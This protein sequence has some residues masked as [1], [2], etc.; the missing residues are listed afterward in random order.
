MLDGSGCW[1]NIAA[2]SA[3]PASLSAGSGRS[4]PSMITCSTL[5]VTENWQPVSRGHSDTRKCSEV[6]I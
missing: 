3:E 5:I 6:L 4:V 1:Q 2:R